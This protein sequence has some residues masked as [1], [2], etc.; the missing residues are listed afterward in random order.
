MTNPS[1]TPLTYNGYVTQ[2]ATMAV[3]NTTTTS[4]VVVGV[5]ASFNAIIPQMLN[6]AEL[7][8]QQDLDLLQTQVENATYTLTAGSNKLAIDVND[9]VTLQ[10]IQVTASGASLPLLPTTKEF[11]QNV[12]NSSTGATVPMYFA[13]YGGD[14]ATYGNNT[15]T[16]LL[17]PWPDQS[18]PVVLTGTIRMQTLYVNATQ[19][20]ANTGTT[21][22][23][24]NLPH[25]L[26]M[27]SMVYISAFQRNFGRES[28]DPQMAQSY[29]NQYQLLLKGSATEEYRKK[30]EADG[31]TSQSQPVAATPTRG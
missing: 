12:Y 27:A 22:I 31:W 3:V 11:L 2:V 24:V 28:D 20:L 10:T 26:I 29:E 30:F 16:F 17:G 4:G 15:Q 13:P 1:T 14:L 19:A 25:L 6:Y 7:R 18:Y 5:D 21:F 9:F 23:S 8:I